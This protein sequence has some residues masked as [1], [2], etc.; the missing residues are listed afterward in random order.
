MKI[1]KNILIYY[2]LVSA[3]LILNVLVLGKL[4][5]FLNYDSRY[6][7]TIQNIGVSSILIFLFLFFSGFIIK[8]LFWFKLNRNLN[9]LKVSKVLFYVPPINFILPFILSFAYYRKIKNTNL[10]CI[11]TVSLL[12]FCLFILLLIISVRSNTQSFPIMAFGSGIL[13]YL[14]SAYTIYTI[15]WEKEEDPINLIGEI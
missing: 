1:T 14:L 10:I 3:L 8:N 13:S 2:Y 12:L 7:E 9:F 4:D 11:Q 5:I 15:N 6:S